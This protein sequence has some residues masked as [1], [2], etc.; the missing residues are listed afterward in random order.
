M[1]T[2]IQYGFKRKGSHSEYWYELNIGNHRFI[3]S[4]SNFLKNDWII[5]YSNKKHSWNETFWFNDKLK[6]E[7]II[8]PVIF[9][10]LTGKEILKYMKII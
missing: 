8:F 3:T 6:F 1:E 2:P 4:D 9:K 10:S 5:G 7:S